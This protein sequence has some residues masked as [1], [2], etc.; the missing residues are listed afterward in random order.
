M[1]YSQI[2]Q[3]T[4]LA[5]LS[6]LLDDVNNSYWTTDELTRYIYEALRTW[7]SYTAYY[8]NRYSLNVT[9]NTPFYDLTASGIVSSD[10]LVFTSLDSDLMKQ[11]EYSLLEPPNTS[12]TWAGTSQFDYNSIVNAMQARRDKFLLDSGMFLTRQLV[13]TSSG[14]TTLSNTM[15]DV[16][17][18]AWKDSISGIT[19]AL[20]KE[21]QWT[22]D[23][24]DRTYNQN[25]GLPQVYSVYPTPQLLIDVSPPPSNTGTLD[26]ITV[27]SGAA[28]NPPSGVLLGIPDDFT[29]VL[30]FGALADLL[31]S[32]GE[33]FDPQRA[34]YCESRYKEG[35]ELA[36]V[37]TSIT[38]AQ[39]SASPAQVISL[40]DQDTY[41]ST[42]QNPSTAYF[43]NGPTPDVISAGYNLASVYP[44]STTT[45]SLT[46]DLIIPAPVTSAYIQVSNSEYDAIIQ[47]ARHLA[48]FKCGGEEF[49]DSIS[50]YQNLVSQA[51]LYNARVKAN[52]RFLKVLKRSLENDMERPR[53]IEQKEKEAAA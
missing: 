2:T 30:R 45:S 18:V 23:N 48:V 19:T 37:Y 44:L 27:N 46:L 1:P 36:R 24:Y 31:S 51:M 47:Y 35:C 52:A 53:L 25:P 28:L 4:A 6:L 15:L 16:R 38:S 12:S 29:W 3:A 32:E 10:P 22:I 26:V 7:S 34:Q 39:I 17:R 42:W 50:A 21:D 5:Q 9:A 43:N 20:W 13:T 8:R 33:R 49:A 14:R 41:K 40:F 11:I